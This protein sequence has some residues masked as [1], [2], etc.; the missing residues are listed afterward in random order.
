MA[1]DPTGPTSSGTM[2]APPP[3][4]FPLQPAQYSAQQEGVTNLQ[5]I[6]ILNGLDQRQVEQE[7]IMNTL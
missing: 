1:V 3:Q 4:Q 5:M 2:N 7:Q 6:Q